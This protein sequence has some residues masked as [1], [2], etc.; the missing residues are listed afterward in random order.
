MEQATF[1][2]IT[3][4]TLMALGCVQQDTDG[5][6]REEGWRGSTGQQVNRAT[7]QHVNRS[8][9]QQV[10]KSIGHSREEGWRG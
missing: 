3:E 8:T 7:G 10:N 5:N 9:G 6:S 1:W 2:L 4:L